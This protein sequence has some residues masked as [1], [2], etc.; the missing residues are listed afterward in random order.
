[1]LPHLV[2]LES[3]FESDAPR[4]YEPDQL[5]EYALAGSDYWADLALGWVEQGVWGDGV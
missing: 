5:V 2:D 1:M 3:W 4:D